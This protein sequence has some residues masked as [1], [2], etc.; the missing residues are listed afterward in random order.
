M[1][2][3]QRPADVHQDELCQSNKTYALIDAKNKV[4]LE[5]PLCPNES[6][7]RAY[8]LK[9]HP[10]RFSIAT[11]SSVPWIYL[12]QFWHTLHE[13]G[14]KYTLKFMLDRKEL[15]QVH[16]RQ[17]SAYSD[18]EKSI[19]TNNNH[20]LFVPAPKFPEI[21][22]F[23]VN[24]L[25]YTLDLRSTSNFKTTGLLQPWQTLCKMFSRC[26]TTRVTGYDQPSLQIM[27][28]LYCFVSDIHADDLI[29]E[30]T[31]QV[32]LAEQK[33]CEELEATQNVEKVKEHLIAEEI[34]ELVK[35]SENVEE[36]VE[37]HTSPLRNDDNQ[38]NLS[39]R[40]AK[41]KHVEEIKNTPSPTT[42]RSPKIQTNLVSLDTEKLQ[43]LTKSISQP[44]SSTPS[45]SSPKSKKFHELAKKL[46][47]VM[48]EALPKLVDDRIK[49]LLKKQV[50]LYVAEGLILEREKIQ[51]DVAKMIV[52]AIQQEHKNL[53]LEISSQVNDVIAN[54]IPSH[55]DSSVRFYM[56]G[57]I[58]HVHPAK[59]TTPSAQEQ[60]Y[61]LYLTMKDD[62]QLQKDN[63]SIWLAFK[64]KFERLHVAPTPCRPFAVRLR[65]RDDPHDDAHPESENS[66]KRHETSEHGTFEIG[67]SSS[68]QDYES[69]PGP[70]TSGNQ[71]QSDDFDYW[72]N[73]YAID[74]DVLHNEKVSQ[75]F[76]DEI[77]QTVDEVKLRKVVDE[78]LRHQCTSRDEHQY[79]IDQMQN[80]L[81][82][83]VA[84][85]ANGSILSITES[86]YKNLNKNDIKD[87]YL[88]IV[89]HKVDDYAE[90]GLLWSLSVF[91][92]STVIWK[93]VHDFQ[94]G[95]ESYQQQVNLTAPTITFLCIEKYEVFSI[96]S[97]PV[98][99]IIY[100][101]NK[102]EKRVMRHQDVHKF[103]DATLKR[104]LEGLKS[105]NNNVKYGYVTHNLIKDEVEY[106]Q[107]FVE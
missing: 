97:E 19:A 101:N 29:L 86:D 77:S 18:T 87:M 53:C 66:T 1:A 60:Q 48:M 103:C 64:I 95:V 91:I 5:N 24:N 35:G 85:R 105:Y 51:A 25:G 72:T 81:K 11:S 14:S 2:Q 32:S 69:E 43:E 92:R 90:T 73:S 38:N 47:D 79:H 88:L 40:R 65:D 78:M 8:I 20:D 26:L 50:S 102:K 71:E 16:A 55:V 54:H 17:K 30:D 99:G 39:T 3:P 28:M 70:S 74:D 75:E 107:L 9:N 33:S 44:S 104:V 34:E 94:L 31:L 41:G 22:P 37:V 98:Y 21:V 10:L 106:L 63:V 84:R 100:D 67:G 4:A 46:E 68:D 62:L 36:N 59:D 76:V 27:Q 56:T 61:Q 58:L 52:E 82:K 93:R 80:F 12:G 96:I 49:V 7:I 45:S 13:D 6:K 83:V 42:I 15:A 23:Y 57:H 89:N